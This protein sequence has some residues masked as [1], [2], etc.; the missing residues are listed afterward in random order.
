MKKTEYFIYQV[1]HNQW[2]Q[3]LTKVKELRD[4]FISNHSIE[5]IVDEDIKITPVA[6]NQT[7]FVIKLTYY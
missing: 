2:Q 6:G 4:T 1:T 3:G 5:K 7:N